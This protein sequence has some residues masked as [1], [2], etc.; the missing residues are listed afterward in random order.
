MLRCKANKEQRLVMKVGLFIN[1]QF[2]EGFNVGE[3]VAEAI[4]EQVKVQRAQ[5]DLPRCDFLVFG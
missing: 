4:V 1:T 3:H 2:P 5:Q